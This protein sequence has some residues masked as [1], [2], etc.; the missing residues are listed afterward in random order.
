MA[1]GPIVD[2]PA[3]IRALSERRIAGAGLDTFEFEPL[4]T[5]SPLWNMRN[6]VIT[7]HVTPAVPDRTMRSLDII[8]ENIRR[9]EAGEPLLN[10]LTAE[11]AYARPSGRA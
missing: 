5:D 2:E 6:V 1:R 10:R 8:C 7:P 11:D 4:P 3:L 9:F